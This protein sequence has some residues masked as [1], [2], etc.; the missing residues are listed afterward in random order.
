VYSVWGV[1]H[2][3]TVEMTVASG[4][5][6]LIS[7]APRRELGLGQVTNALPASTP[8][9]GREPRL[10][11]CASG[12]AVRIWVWACEARCVL[13]VWEL[14]TANRRSTG[15]MLGRLTLAVLV[16]AC[17]W[18]PGPAGRSAALGP[19]SGATHH[20]RTRV[21][22]VCSQKEAP[23]VAAAALAVEGDPRTAGLEVG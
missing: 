20:W 11:Q 15:A 12:V 10:Q 23:A 1:A 9:S 3:T 13:S 8:K 6:R 2:L 5:L 19:F 16:R 22:D 21:S 7:T 14:S 17:C 4:G 18:T